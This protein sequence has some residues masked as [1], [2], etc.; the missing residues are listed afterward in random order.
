M[1]RPAGLCWDGGGGVSWGAQGGG[2]GSGGCTSGPCP[3]Q[4]GD[5]PCP[6]PPLLTRSTKAW[7]RL[8]TEAPGWKAGST[9]SPVAPVP[10]APPPRRVPR[11]GEQGCLHGSLTGPLAC[12][13][14]V[15]NRDITKG[16]SRGQ[17]HFRAGRGLC[18]RRPSSACSFDEWGSRDLAAQLQEER[19][20]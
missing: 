8:H 9:P 2:T 10:P 5:L 19:R 6:Q 1:G 3:P 15:I 7:S 18:P 13:P 12:L 20:G 14:A 11:A 16:I 17:G 4:G